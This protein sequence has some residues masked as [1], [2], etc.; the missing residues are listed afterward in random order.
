M[1][2]AFLSVLA[3]IAAG[4]LPAQQTSL[5]GPIE[6]YTFDAPTRSLRA[7]IGFPG[8]ASFGPELIDNLDFAS[9]A[10]H[11]NYGIVLEGGKWLSVS[12]L[13]SK[14]STVAIAGVT[15]Y[16]DGIVW[17]ANG[18]V[19]VLYSHGGNWFQTISGLP[20]APVAGAPVDTS[21]LI[22]TS[23]G[24]FTAIA[25]DAQ[26][27]QIAVAVSGD[28]GGVYQVAN[29][30]F[31]LLASMSKPVSLAFSTD[32]ET[33]FA[34]DAA[35]LQITAANWN[36]SGLQ[37]LALPGMTNP[38]A[39]QAL[40]DAQNRTLLYIAGGTDRILRMLDV[41][42]QQ[43]VSDI[44]LSLQ[45]TD[46]QPFGSGS[47]VLVSRAQSAK[48]LWLFSSAPLPGSYFVPAVQLQ[49]QIRTNLAVAGRTR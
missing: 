40:E 4:S 26:G 8:A 23:G 21:S 49:Q 1:R 27:K 30:Q 36:G 17:A 39:I 18:S 20:T 38:I 5:S 48:P 42:S 43:I 35:A 10:P 12:G 16:P 28:T 3:L 19:A 15:K 37:T 6:A 46:L 34:L 29:G 45:P 2:L 41:T 11:L 33:L 25:I 22:S 24:S 14:L 47:F 13:G 32:G 9:V 7:V 44:S 31:M